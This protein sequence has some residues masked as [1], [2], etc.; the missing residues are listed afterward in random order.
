MLSGL[1]GEWLGV[2]TPVDGMVCVMAERDWYNLNRQ[3]KIPGGG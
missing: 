2:G 1:L 3:N